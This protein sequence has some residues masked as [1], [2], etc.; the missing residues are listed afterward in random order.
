[1]LGLPP[2]TRSLGSVISTTHVHRSLALICNPSSIPL[3]PKVSDKC[4]EEG[5]VDILVGA[6]SA[7]SNSGPARSSRKECSTAPRSRTVDD[8]DVDDAE[9]RSSVDEAVDFFLPELL[10]PCSD[11]DSV[12][13]VG[14]DP[15]EEVREGPPPPAKPCI[16][17]MDSLA[18]H[19]AKEIYSNLRMYVT[20]PFAQVDFTFFLVVGFAHAWWN[21]WVSCGGTGTSKLNG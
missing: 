9:S 21:C 3:L 2:L 15:V 12:E 10:G 18:A 11:T 17:L 6:S 1:M 13:V 19:P 14:G 8:D 20:F 16:V 7:H 4:A 5:D